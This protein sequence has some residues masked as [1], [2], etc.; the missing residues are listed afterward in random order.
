MF[1]FI[2][3]S[4]LIAGWLLCGYLP[5]FAWSVATRGNAGLRFLPLCLFAG[6]VAGL[7]VPILGFDGWWGLLASFVAAVAASA[8]LLT[9]R[10]GRPE[11]K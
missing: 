9:A 2:F 1:D 3:L 10:P 11:P 4:L 7:A 8:V 6:L 5:W